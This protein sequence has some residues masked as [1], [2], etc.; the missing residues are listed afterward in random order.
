LDNGSDE[1][2]QAVGTE[3]I[4]RLEENLGNCI[5]RNMGIDACET[6]YYFLLDGDILYVRG[7]I[8][9]LEDLMDKFPD[10]GI[11]GTHREQNVRKYGYNGVPERDMADIFAQEPYQV[12]EGMPMAWTQCGLF[13]KT[14]Q[15]FTTIPPFDGPGH[16]FE[17]SWYYHEMKEKG[18]KSY[19]IN[20]ISYY[21]EAHSGQ[22]Q[23]DKSKVDDKKKLR[24]DKFIERFGKV[25]WLHKPFSIETIKVKP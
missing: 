7:S 23:L 6:P 3:K 24:E 21:H 9:I 18:L 12:F 2:Y 1:P 20:T 5:P 25:D 14:D 8:K 13:R 11:V 10:A 4:I 17:D 15:R 19:F 22:R 16:G